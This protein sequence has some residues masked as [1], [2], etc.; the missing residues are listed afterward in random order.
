MAEFTNHTMILQNDPGER[1]TVNRGSGK[2][3]ADSR[4]ADLRTESVCSLKPYTDLG[5]VF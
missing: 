1:L 2:L 4:S 3:F 5:Q